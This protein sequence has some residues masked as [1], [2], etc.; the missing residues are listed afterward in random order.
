[1]AVDRLDEINAFVGVADARS[2]TQAARRLGVS[3]A[4]VSS[5]VARK[6][7]AVGMV[8]CAAPDYLARAGEPRTPED[9]VDHEAVLDTNLADAAVWRF[10]PAGAKREV[11]VGGR[12]RFSGAAACVAAARAG[13]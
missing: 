5:L 10:G 3:S 12:L 11:R 6:L 13:F 7:A 9:L 8:T 2:F 1:M 4:Q